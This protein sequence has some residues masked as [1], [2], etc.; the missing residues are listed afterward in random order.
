MVAALALCTA[1]AYAFLIT[2]GTKTPPNPALAQAYEMALR[3]LG[4]E[5]NAFYCLKADAMAISETQGPTE[6]H[7]IFYSTNGQLREV[8][9]PTSGKV[10][11]RD[12]LRDGY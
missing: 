11:V 9:V 7:L 5:T 3:T 8:I 12:K 1:T 2:R 4:P 6:W 10:I